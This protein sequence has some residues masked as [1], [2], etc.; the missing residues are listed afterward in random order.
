[1]DAILRIRVVIWCYDDD[2]GVFLPPPPLRQGGVDMRRART[3]VTHVSIHGVGVETVNDYMY[4][5][6]HVD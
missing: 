6:A 1:M 4:F 3:S 5:G 2:D